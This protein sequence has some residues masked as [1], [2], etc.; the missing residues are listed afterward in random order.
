MNGQEQTCENCANWQRYPNSNMGWCPERRERMWK[1]QAF[2]CIFY[3]P[4]ES[5][6]EEVTP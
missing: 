6:Q 3:Q 2:G 1:D 4:A 5:D